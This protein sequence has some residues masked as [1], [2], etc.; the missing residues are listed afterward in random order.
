M[1]WVLKRDGVAGAEAVAKAAEEAFQQYPHWHTSEHQEQP[2]RKAFYKALI[3]TGVDAL[4]EVCQSLL[5]LLRRP[6]ICWPPRP[7]SAAR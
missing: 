3:D 5:K 7:R 2:V 4:V 1:Y 6:T